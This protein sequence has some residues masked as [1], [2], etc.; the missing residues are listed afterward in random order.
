MKVRSTVFED[1]PPFRVVGLRVASSP[2][3]S[4]GPSTGRLDESIESEEVFFTLMGE[5]VEAW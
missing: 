2:R 4:G 5:D 1:L 3:H